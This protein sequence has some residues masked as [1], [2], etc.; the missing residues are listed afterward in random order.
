MEQLIRE[1]FDTADEQVKFF[2]FSKESC[3]IS[4]NLN[5]NANTGAPHTE[6]DSVY[7]LIGVPHQEK[8]VL[9]QFLFHEIG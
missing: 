6:R 8:E 4:G 1:V 9:L 5:F 3:F 7:T 2:T